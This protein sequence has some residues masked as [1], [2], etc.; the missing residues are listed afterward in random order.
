M[1]RKFGEAM[2]NSLILKKEDCEIKLQCTQQ[3]IKILQAEIDKDQ[4]RKEEIIALLDETIEAIAVW[5]QHLRV[6]KSVF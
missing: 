4:K 1:K 3:N 2:L 6:K 5:K